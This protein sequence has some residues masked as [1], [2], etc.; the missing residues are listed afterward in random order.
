MFRR[1][2]RKIR[3]RREDSA[4]KSEN[5]FEELQRLVGEMD[6]LSFREVDDKLGVH[7][8][9]GNASGKGYQSPRFYRRI[10]VLNTEEKR[11]REDKAAKVLGRRN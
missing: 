6:G 7:S 5:T 10:P 3:A 1:I 8:T 9:N 11:K 2:V 4:A